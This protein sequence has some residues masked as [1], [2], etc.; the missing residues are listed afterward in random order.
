[1]SKVKHYPVGNGDQTLITV[2]ENG[3][4]TNIL[5]DCRI[6]NESLGS[7]DPEMYDVKADLIRSLQKRTLNAVEAVSY[8]DNYI[9]THGDKDHLHGFERHFYQGKPQDYKKK[10]KDD[11]EIFI[12][13]MWFSPMVMGTA[14]NSDEEVFNKE[15]KRRIQL[16]R[17]KSPD[18]DLPGNRIVIIGYDG[19][20]KLDGLDLVR[21]EPGQVVSRF[22]NRDL[23]TFSIFIH[24]PYQQGLTDEDVD[25]NRVSLVFQARFKANAY[26]TEFCAL[27]MFAGDAN[28]E[29]IKEIID[30]TIRHNNKAALQWDIFIAPHHCSW[31][32]FNECPQADYPDP[33]KTSLAFLSYRRANGKVIA[34][35]KV[36]KD[37]GDDPPHHEAKEQYVKAVGGKFFLELAT[38][39][40]PSDT[41]APLPIE[42][43]ITPG[44]PMKPKAPEGT[45]IAAGT[46]SLPTVGKTSSYGSA[47]E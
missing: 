35:C 10:N 9:L 27:F 5:I 26:A 29:A 1:M 2:N 34:S 32:Y 18:K 24:S 16:H 15:A 17:D 11:G 14:T 28:H 45:A 7:P 43:E 33:Q 21:Y 8:V 6:R 36:I 38:E 37:D 4:I 31:T 40:R 20:E 39:N 42:F 19:N 3:Q 30:K 12:D 44:G 41:G 25:K 46:G 47:T 22:N 23:Q 13:T